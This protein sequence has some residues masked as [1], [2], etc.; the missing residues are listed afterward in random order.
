MAEYIERDFALDVVKRTSGDY[1]CAFSEIAHA[2]AADVA[3]VVRC[4]ACRY[5]VGNT[6][7]TGET[8]CLWTQDTVPPDGFCWR[9]R[10]Q[11]NAEKEG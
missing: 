3:Q 9:G 7:F 2:P 11:T 1:A 6:R 10:L 8:F 5:C 4:R